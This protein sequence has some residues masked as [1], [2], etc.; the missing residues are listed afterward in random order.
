VLSSDFHAPG[1]TDFRSYLAKIK[2][3]NPEGICI[4]DVSSP[5]A[6]EVKEIA[7]LG[8]KTTVLAE[9]LCGCDQERSARD[10]RGCR[11]NRRPVLEKFALDSSVTRA[12]WTIGEG[13]EGVVPNTHVTWKAEYLYMD[14]G[15]ENYTFG[16]CA[17]ERNAY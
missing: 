8:I 17:D 10:R 13:I 15:T 4:V 9:A 2:D 14:L 11:H 16:A 7:E 1:E 6:T 5:A 12:G 3:L